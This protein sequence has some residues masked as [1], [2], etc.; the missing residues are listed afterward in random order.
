MMPNVTFIIVNWNGWKDTIE[1]LESI[2]QIKYSRY[3]VIIVDN[4]SED[5]SVKKILE[6][7]DG[8]IKVDS[9][10][11]QYDFKNKP[12][13]VFECDKYKTE[14]LIPFEKVLGQVLFI[15]NKFNFGFAVGNNIAIE[16]ALKYLN[17]D[18]FL[19]LNND[20]VVKDDFLSELINVSINRNFGVLSPTVYDYN[21]DD[22]IQFKI[23]KIRWF[24]GRITSE[25]INFDK[26]IE[27]SDTIT[28]ASMLIKRNVIERIGLL[29]T[30][31][32]MLW[33]D[34]D[35]VTMAWRNNINC[36][37]VTNSKIWHKGSA[38]IGVFSPMRI[39]FSMRNRPIFW[40]KYSGKYQYISFLLFWVLYHSP[41]VLIM[42]L[43]KSTKKINF[44]MYFL[45][46]FTDGIRFNQ[47]YYKK[48]KKY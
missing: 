40:K 29:P 42:G 39:K 38:S 2:F 34:I 30:E 17:S 10:F 3:T 48:K 11:F 1:C 18:Y 33:E 21:D 46:G 45:K 47:E 9:R 19:L 7:C 28:G 4:A 27:E 14:S 36:G 35:Y 44:L 23:E 32:F 5:D 12:I 13:N 25:N 22:K 24:T 20:T 43:T 15:R 16:F 31:Y 26:K 8:K 41:T 6:Y 37:Y